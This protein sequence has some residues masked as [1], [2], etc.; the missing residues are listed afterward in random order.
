MTDDETTDDYTWPHTLPCAERGEGPGAGFADAD[1]DANANA[2]G[3]QLIELPSD[4]LCPPSLQRVSKI[5]LG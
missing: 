5:G 1:A 2:D 3:S 4:P